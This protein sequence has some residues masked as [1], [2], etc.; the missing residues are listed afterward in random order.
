MQLKSARDDDFGRELVP[1]V[2][3]LAT[4]VSLV[5]CNT[6]FISLRYPGNSTVIPLERHYDTNEP[7]LQRHRNAHLKTKQKLNVLSS[8]F[9]FT[10]N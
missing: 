3:C 9:Y 4:L 5:F 7:P 8:N 6:T 2:A 1:F 10:L